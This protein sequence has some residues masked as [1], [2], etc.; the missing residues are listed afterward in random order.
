MQIYSSSMDTTIRKWNFTDQ[1]CVTC[2]QLEAPVR[3][4]VLAGPDTI[5]ASLQSRGGDTGR[6]GTYCLKTKRW[7]LLLRLSSP[8]RALALS[9]SEEYIATFER[10]TLHIV[11]LSQSESQPAVI[12]LSHSKRFTV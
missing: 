12:K 1:E 10:H 5:V 2:I 11:Q 4:M 8:S 9:P 7:K 3:N 6:V